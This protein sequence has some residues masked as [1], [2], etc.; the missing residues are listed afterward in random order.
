MDRFCRYLLAN[1]KIPLELRIAYA[2]KNFVGNHPI[3]KK[4]KGL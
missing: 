1:T 2:E 3:H 4:L